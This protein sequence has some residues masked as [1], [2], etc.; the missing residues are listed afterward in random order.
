[1]LHT[2]KRFVVFFLLLFAVLNLAFATTYRIVDYEFDVDGHTNKWALANR[3]KGSDES[4]DSIEA[5]ES[6]LESKRQTLWNT[7]LFTTVKCYWK[8]VA[9][10]D[11]YVDV[12]AVIEVTDTGQYILVPYPK[13]DS[14]T[15]FSL[16]LRYKNNN[17]FGTLGKASVSLDWDQN[18]S[19]FDNSSF[20]LE[21]P[22]SNVL[23]SNGSVINMNVTGNYSVDSPDDAEL[24]FSTGISNLKIKDVTLAGSFAIDYKH[25]TKNFD[26]FETALSASGFRFNEVYLDTSLSSELYFNSS[27]TSSYIK[28]VV[29]VRN[30]KLGDKVTVSDTIAYNTVPKDSEKLWSFTTDEIN[31]VTTFGIQSDVIKGLSVTAE[32]TFDILEKSQYYR[33]SVGFNPLP[34][35]S[36]TTTLKGYSSEAH[37]FYAFNV[38]QGFSTSFT[39]PYVKLNAV[40]F[41]TFINKNA[42]S[43]EVTPRAW[44]I[45]TGIT[46]SGGS[47]NRISS[48]ETYF[49]FRDNFRTGITT[50]AQAMMIWEPEKDPDVIL[51]GAIT[52]FWHPFKNFNPSFRLYAAA[53]ADPIA[54][55]D[56][57]SGNTYA[58]VSTYSFSGYTMTKDTLNSL[59]RGVRL[60]SDE[61]QTTYTTNYMGFFSTNLTTS[62]LYFEDFGHL[63]ISPFLDAAVFSNDFSESY[64]TVAGAGLEGYLI[65]DNHTS[66][67]IRASVGFDLESLVK[68]FQGEDVSIGFEIFIG[69]G[70]LY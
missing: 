30:I 40:P 4:F 47:I 21:A 46:V 15:G 33:L 32:E 25:G 57:A 48:G 31:N 60:D 58:G 29:T 70:L 61:I 13:Y 3:V 37:D 16:G 68:K 26:E 11:E 10:Y 7:N 62:F 50:L 9:V 41:V 39:V 23:L 6:A 27:I 59:I 69:L 8:E 54:W 63:Y 12:I 22:I 14:N 51:R 19:D 55:F 36:S 65:M 24:N 20:E 1:M 56:Q 52:A 53:A 18:G 17:V 45:D 28:P 67:P 34:K 2:N 66:Y 35:V 38:S 43:Y 64:E 44:E 42:E 5:L 49:A